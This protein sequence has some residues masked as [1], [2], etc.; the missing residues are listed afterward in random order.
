[1]LHNYT[2]DG[3]TVT[4]CPAHAS[5][6]GEAEDQGK[7]NGGKWKCQVCTAARRFEGG[8]ENPE[9]TIING[10]VVTR[11]PDEVTM[12][13]CPSWKFMRKPPKERICKHIEEWNYAT[14]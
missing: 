1:M 13:E 10:Y 4:L 9:S 12:C 14:A 8:L 11:Y 6:A 7:T 3:R 5:L 2:I